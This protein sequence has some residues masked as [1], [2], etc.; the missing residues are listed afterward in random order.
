MELI[1]AIAALFL[2]V[3]IF[4]WLLKIVKT[5]IQTA[6]FVAIIVLLLQ[7]FFGIGPQQVFQQVSQI[8][9]SILDVLLGGQ[10]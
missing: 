6:I 5:T 2:S 10:Q 8:F 4:F 9:Q 7:V 3:L 1:I